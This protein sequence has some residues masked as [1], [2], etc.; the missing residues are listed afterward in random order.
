M[1]VAG[2]SR[3]RMDHSY[4]FETMQAKIT[5]RTTLPGGE[6]FGLAVETEIPGG[7]GQEAG[8]RLGKLF[9]AYARG[10]IELATRGFSHSFEERQ[11][12]R[13]MYLSCSGWGADECECGAVYNCNAPRPCPACGR[14]DPNLYLNRDPVDPERD[15]IHTWNAGKVVVRTSDGSRP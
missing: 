13:R 5:A 15:F 7:I 1:G 10:I 6:S 8:I 11:E 12:R 9:V 3:V 14:P 4:N 2:M